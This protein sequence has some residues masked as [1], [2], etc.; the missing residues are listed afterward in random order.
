MSIFEYD[1]KAVRRVLKKE[2]YED[3]KIEGKIEDI[4]WLLEEA[5]SVPEKLREKIAAEK[6][7]ETLK[8]WLKLAA[9][10]ENAE[11]FAKKAKLS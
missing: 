1:E 5:G 10:A 8:G 11:E 3:G 6:D 7:E 9:A 2:A 4:I